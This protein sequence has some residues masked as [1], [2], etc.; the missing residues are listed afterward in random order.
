MGMER[1]M[2][3]KFWCLSY[4]EMKSIDEDLN[5]KTEPQDLNLTRDLVVPNSGGGGVLYKKP[6]RFKRPG[7]LVS[8]TNS[9][10]FF[11]ANLN[12]YSIGG[13]LAFV[14]SSDD[15][16]IRDSGW[17]LGCVL[18]LRTARANA[19]IEVPMDLK[20]IHDDDVDSPT[21]YSLEDDD[22]GDV[23]DQK[24]SSDDILEERLYDEKSEILAPNL[25]HAIEKEIDSSPDNLESGNS[26]PVRGQFRTLQCM[27]DPPININLEVQSLYLKQLPTTHHTLSPQT[28]SFLPRTAIRFSFHFSH[29]LRSVVAPTTSFLLL[30]LGE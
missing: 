11:V 28:F 30:I 6:T 15:E 20:S 21:F 5:L 25:L 24:A 14:I 8:F 4:D 1:V 3:A 19:A 9:F 29:F 26:F 17:Y 13:G 22:F 10:P 16:T 2:N 18:P 27:I 12:P 7:I 23:T